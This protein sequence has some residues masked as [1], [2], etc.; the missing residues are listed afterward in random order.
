MPRLIA[1]AQDLE[2]GL[3][4]SAELVAEAARADVAAIRLGNPGG[5]IV[6]AAVPS[7]VAASTP[8][9]PAWPC[10]W[11]CA[12]AASACSPSP[13]SAG[14]R[15]RR[16]GRGRRSVRRPDRAG[17]RQRPTVRRATGPPGRAAPAGRGQRGGRRARTTS[18]PW[19]PRSPGAPPTWWRPSGRPCWCSTRSARRWSPCPRRTASR[20][21][22]SGG[23]G[24]ASSDGGPNVQRL[25]ERSSLH[26]QRRHRRPPAIRAGRRG[27]SRSSR[28]WPCPCARSELVRR[29]ARLQQA[30]RPVHSPGCS[31]AG[32]VRG[33]GGRSARKCDA[34]TSRPST[35]ASS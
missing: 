7:A 26:Q 12:V 24:S 30:A 14:G 17:R 16:R 1:S 10:R 21:L 29:A 5:T 28:C 31:P 9:R 25:R 11:S 15:S 4:R 6:H 32:R 35:S 2:E 3:R 33:P 20:P 27:R 13:D 34:C 18:T 19:R 23:C 22:T 8:C